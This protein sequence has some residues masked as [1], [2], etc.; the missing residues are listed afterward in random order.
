MC[1]NWHHCWGSHKKGEKEENAQKN[2][3][4][5]VAQVSIKHPSRQNRWEI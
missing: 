4:K 2:I 3:T 5:M 1:I